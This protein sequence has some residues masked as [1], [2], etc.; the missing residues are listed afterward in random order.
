VPA[1]NIGVFANPFGDPAPD[2]E[3]PVGSGDLYLYAGGLWVGAFL[4]GEPRVSTA[5]FE[6]ELLPDCFDPVDTIYESTIGMEGGAPRIG[7]DHD[8]MVDEEHRNGRDDDGDGY[9]DEDFAAISEE[10]LS[11][12]YKDYQPEA[13]EM[14]P[15]HVP[16]HVDIYEES[17]G[18][19]SRRDFYIYSYEVSNAGWQ[20][21]E[22]VTLGLWIDP[23]VGYGYAYYADDRVGLGNYE[24]YGQP[25]SI[26]Y[27]FDDGGQVPGYVGLL[28][29]GYGRSRPFA[30]HP[31]WNA[32]SRFAGALVFPNGDP[33]NDSQRFAAMASSVGSSSG[34]D[35][36]RFLAS[37][38]PF[39]TLNPGET[40]H[41]DVALV[42]GNGFEGMLRTAA[43]AAKFYAS[44][45]EAADI[46][47]TEPMARPAPPA[48]AP[49]GEGLTVESG[50]ALL[51]PAA[52]C[53]GMP[54]QDSSPHS[55]SETVSPTAARL[56]LGPV[57]ANPMFD[58]ACVRF[59]LDRET[60][61]DLEVFDV[62][63][64]CVRRILSG[65]PMTRGAQRA[66]WE[67]TDDTGRLLPTGVYWIRLT[68][69]E[70][71]AT[72]KAIIAR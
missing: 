4:D 68:A 41:L 63:G 19:S 33:E 60:V 37:V 21:L 13:Q 42:I 43:R 53:K 62:A 72:G 34:P 6:H 52:V 30:P 27:G 49:S 5:V 16:L 3:W 46:P 55:A 12:E 39:P 23:D 11:C 15:D 35:D 61:V 51:R 50:K 38:S 17:H 47:T 45:C 7:D 24:Y 1:T 56:E 48:A 8:G 54:L 32:V 71:V 2:C 29:L 31:V 10:M 36:M 18:W 59:S 67:G 65:V 9:I 40:V 57:G 25:L 14:Y 26:A 66:T 70:T 20:V 58:G 64:R 44:D 28:L 69:G 22:D